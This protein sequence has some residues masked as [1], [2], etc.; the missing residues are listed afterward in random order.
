M[1]RSSE[2]R[3]REDDDSSA[4]V[5]CC[6]ALE[7][8]SSAALDAC[9]HCF[10]IDCIKQWANVRLRSLRCHRG[11]LRVTAVLLR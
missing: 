9:S 10:H 3:P 2:E 7:G 6:D 1:P 8:P 11:A 4:Y 5:I